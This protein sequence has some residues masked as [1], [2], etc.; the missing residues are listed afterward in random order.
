MGLGVVRTIG[1]RLPM[2]RNRPRRLLQ[3]LQSD[4]DAVLG[5][6]IARPLVARS[7]DQTDC[8][9]DAAPLQQNETEIVKGIKVIAVLPEYSSIEGFG[10]VMQSLLVEGDRCLK[11][12]QECVGR[13][14]L[15]GGDGPR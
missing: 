3:R 2:V 7:A 13:R 11:G 9:V 1:E 6:G 4:A 8:L 15:S 5:L 10:L 12:L 14:S